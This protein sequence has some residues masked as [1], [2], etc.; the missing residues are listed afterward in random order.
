MKTVVFFERQLCERGTTIALFDYA[1]YNE[2]ILNN[3]SIIFYEK[4]S[5]KNNSLVIEKFSKRFQ[6]F[7]VEEFKDIDKVLL[8][9]SIDCDLIYILKY[10][11]IDGRISNRFKTGVHCVFE[12]WEPH[13]DVYASISPQL[14]WYNSSIPVVPHIVSLPDHDRDMREELGIPQNALVYGRHG[15]LETFS[16]SYVQQAVYRVALQ[17]PEIFFIFVNTDRFCETLPNIIH[18]QQIIDIEK[19]VEFINTCD[20][21]IWGRTEGETFGLA[22]AEFSIRNKPVFC[23]KSGDLAH[24]DK[25]GDKAIIY[26]ENTIESMLTHFDREDSKNKDW[27]AYRDYSPEKVMEIFNNVFIGGTHDSIKP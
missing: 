2:T 16:I 11:T 18:L 14:K 8:D 22:I 10:G 26:D 6:V 4:N 25:L 27:N 13:G 21:M 20:A 15:G 12:C 23:C 17:N 3:K 9:N 7:A 24:I 5:P 19:K 1:Y